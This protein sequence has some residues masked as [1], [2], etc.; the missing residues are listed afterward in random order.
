L[1]AYFDPSVSA[2]ISLVCESATR[3]SKR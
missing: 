3:A 1:V 2:A